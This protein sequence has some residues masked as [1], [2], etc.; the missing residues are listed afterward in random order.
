LLPVIVLWSSSLFVV[1]VVV[2]VRCPLSS[3]LSRSLVACLLGDG[4]VALGRCPRDSG[5]RGP[6][7]AGGVAW[8]V[9][10]NEQD[11]EQG[12]RQGQRTRTTTGTTT[13]TTTKGRRP[14]DDDR[15]DD[16]VPAEAQGRA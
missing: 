3:S 1:P 10:V 9:V 8:F 15:D 12:R 14:K 4:D 7:E 11:D 5:V 16:N 6:E 2:L 13:R